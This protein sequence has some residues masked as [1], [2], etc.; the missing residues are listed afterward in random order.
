MLCLKRRELRKA[1][2][3]RTLTAAEQA[4]DKR[5]DGDLK[6][7]AVQA[8]TEI[9]SL[10]QRISH[11]CIPHAPSWPSYPQLDKFRFATM[12]QAR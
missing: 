1:E 2:D 3:K 5:I 10:E 9:D 4:T 11:G 6:S 8:V 12:H 7:R